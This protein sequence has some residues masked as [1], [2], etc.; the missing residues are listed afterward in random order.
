MINT[1]SIEQ[2][3]NKTFIKLKDVASIQFVLQTI[4]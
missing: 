4:C 1:P 2:E 3:Q